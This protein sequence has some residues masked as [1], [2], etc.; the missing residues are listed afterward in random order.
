MAIRNDDDLVLLLDF[1]Y[2]SVQSMQAVAR[3]R[4]RS[5]AREAPTLVRSTLTQLNRSHSIDKIDFPSILVCNI[6]LV[7]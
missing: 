2:L 1:I 4:P 5:R 6:L 7:W 3:Q